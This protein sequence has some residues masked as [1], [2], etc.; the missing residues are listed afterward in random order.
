[1]WAWP[2]GNEIR[3]WNDLLHPFAE[4]RGQKPLPNKNPKASFAQKMTTNYQ[5]YK[6]QEKIQTSLWSIL[7]SHC[8]W[9]V[10][11]YVDKCIHDRAL[12]T[13]LDQGGQGYCWLWQWTGRNW[14]HPGLKAKELMRSAIPELKKSLVKNFEM[15][16][17]NSSGAVSTSCHICRPISITALITQRVIYHILKDFSWLVFTEGDS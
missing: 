17:C 5:S 16:T 2:W 6:E 10:K 1:M 8:P 14:A 13:Q 4:S 7:D 12:E 3:G 9:N 11:G 15:F